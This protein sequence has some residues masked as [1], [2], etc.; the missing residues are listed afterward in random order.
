MAR[1]RSADPR[2]KKCSF[3]AGFGLQ[4]AIDD[5]RRQPFGELS[6]FARKGIRFVP[7][8]SEPDELGLQRRTGISQYRDA[9]AALCDRAIVRLGRPP[10]RCLPAAEMRDEQLG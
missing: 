10:S 5:L 7:M 6:A 4:P 2:G 3:A 9:L 8:R 1:A